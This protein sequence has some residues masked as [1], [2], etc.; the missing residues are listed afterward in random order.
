MTLRDRLFIAIPV[1]DSVALETGLMKQS[2]AR[3]S[4]PWA[5]SVRPNLC[6]TQPFKK[7]SIYKGGGWAE[8]DVYRFGASRAPTD[9][10]L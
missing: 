7:D 1:T 8:R 5:F 10:N 4:S 2:L 3:R 6:H 9:T